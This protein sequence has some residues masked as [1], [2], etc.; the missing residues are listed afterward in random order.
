MGWIEPE[1]SPIWNQTCMYFSNLRVV[2]QV[3]RCLVCA[4]PKATRVIGD[5]TI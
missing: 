3:A 4:V 1:N 5:R 2:E